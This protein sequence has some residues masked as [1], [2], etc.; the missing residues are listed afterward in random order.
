MLGEIREKAMMKISLKKLSLLVM[1]GYNGTCSAGLEL[2]ERQQEFGMGI[3]RPLARRDGGAQLPGK[4]KSSAS[5]GKRFSIMN[6]PVHVIKQV[7]PIIITAPIE[8][9]FHDDRD[10]YEVTRILTG[11]AP[12]LP[13][14]C[15]NKD[16][17][18]AIQSYESYVK[19]MFALED[20]L[21]R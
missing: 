18:N 13:E 10:D 16:D 4:G 21:G 2:Q 20:K 6:E 19:A 14:R 7:E 12:S 17:F 8:I 3:V 15:E 1:L 9:S 11:F 5:V